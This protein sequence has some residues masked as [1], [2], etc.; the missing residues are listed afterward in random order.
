[1]ACDRRTPAAGIFGPASFGNAD[2]WSCACALEIMWLAA[3]VAQSRHG[4]S[5]RRYTPEQY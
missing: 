1:M 2:M 3:R 5:N 4:V